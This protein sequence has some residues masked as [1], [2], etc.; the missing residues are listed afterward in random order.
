VL[1]TTT[2]AIMMAADIETERGRREAEI[3][4]IEVVTEVVTGRTVY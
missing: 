2:L 3:E 1:L 4:R